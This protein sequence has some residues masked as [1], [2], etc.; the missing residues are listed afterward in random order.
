M[1]ADLRFY[2]RLLLRRL[3]VMALLF[4]LCTAMGVVL[5]LRLP[6]VYAA[7]ARLLVEAPQISEELAQ[8]SVQIAATE[9]I[10]IIR[11]QLMTRANLIDIARN[12]SVF[13]EIGRMSPDEIVEEM[14]DNTDIRA[15]GGPS[16]G[17]AQPTIVN[18]TFNARE[19][20]IAAA[21]VNEYITRITSANVR[22]RTDAAGDTLSF[23]E[24]EVERLDRELS[25]RLERISAFQR[26]H[27]DALPDG[28]AY[29]LDRQSLLQERLAG[30][31]RDITGLEEQ[32]ARLTDLFETTGQAA[33]M[34]SAQPALSPEAARVAELEA[35]LDEA[36]TVFSETNPRV[37]Q[38]QGRLERAR[39]ALADSRIAAETGEAQTAPAED[40]QTTLFNLQMAEIDAR[41]AQLRAQIPPIEDELAQLRDAIDETPLNGI[42]LAGL[43]RDYDNIR[44]QYDAAVVRLNQAS[45]GERIE[46]SARGQRITLVEA[47]SVPDSPDSPNRPLVAAAGAGLGL[48]LALGLFVLL[49]LLNSTV[50][51]GADLQAKLGVVP[52]ATIPY[53]ET[54]R[55]RIWRRIG[56]ALVMLA[57]L[58]G[59]PAG[60]WAVDTYY[61]P[62]DLLTQR[63]LD[64]LGLA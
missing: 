25:T 30:L 18:V 40:P 34:Q 35:E 17:V 21:V 22:N 52:L 1:N 54:R 64:R 50:R 11:Q 15:T 24:Q 36:L 63:L 2:A 46:L 26:E 19:G 37:V 33:G 42:T 58:V 9:E 49:E 16:R 48:V 62:L 6:A 10:E 28:Q 13:E 3:P 29:R 56:R 60:L 5:A 59:V 45:M 23:F 8:S 27:V 55:R 20:R 53:L 61:L 31:G 57:V 47:A 7:S 51:R 14:R 43:Q 32:R 39:E 38:L 4:L 12:L 41:V 44:Q